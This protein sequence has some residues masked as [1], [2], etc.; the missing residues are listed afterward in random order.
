M[1]IRVYADNR[2]IVTAPKSL[3]ER[4]VHEFIYAQ[5]RRIEKRLAHNRAIQTSIPTLAPDQLLLH[6][7]TYSL[8]I[9][10]DGAMP[11][12]IDHT[13]KI[14]RSH[15][16]MLNPKIQQEWY[17]SYAKILL[18]KRL[19]ILSVQHELRYNKLAIKDMKTR[20]GSCSS[21]RNISLHWK[22]VQMPEFVMNYIICHELA[23]LEQ[24]NHSSKFWAVV[25]R[26]CNDKNKAIDR[27]K[28]N[29]VRLM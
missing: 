19:D 5:K 24:M 2:I 3:S 17:K 8:K 26:L 11:T 23:H 29:G 18:K 7:S 13:Q 20:R 10:E 14:I 9:N 22:L 1:T 16:T 6:G 28:K 21:R 15:T 4:R 12:Q 25:D 27:M